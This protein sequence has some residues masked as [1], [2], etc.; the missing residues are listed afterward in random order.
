M[1][2]VQQMHGGRDY[3][4][5]FSTRMRGQGVFAELIRRRFDVACRKHGFVRTRELA[6]EVRTDLAAP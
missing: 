2:L 1:S 4:S 6:L 5:D 3:D